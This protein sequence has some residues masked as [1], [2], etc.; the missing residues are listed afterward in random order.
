MEARRRP[1]RNNVG[2]DSRLN[3]TAGCELKER[4]GWLGSLCMYSVQTYQKDENPMPAG[5]VL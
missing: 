5:N 3:L 4:P 1:R 2:G